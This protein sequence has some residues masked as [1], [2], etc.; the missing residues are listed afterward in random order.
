MLECRCPEEVIRRRLTWRH[1]QSTASDADVT[2]YERQ[3]ASNIPVTLPVGN[4]VGNPHH[5][6][7]DTEQPSQHGAHEVVD[8]FTDSGGSTE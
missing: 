3:T 4:D 1:G 6:I 2:V 5:I 7:V 8:R